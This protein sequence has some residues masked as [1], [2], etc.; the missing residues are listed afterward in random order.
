MLTEYIIFED[1]VHAQV[2][3]VR[4]EDEEQAWK[5]YLEQE[6]NYVEQP[7]G[8]Y[9]GKPSD[10]DSLK[11]VFGA[12][13][14]TLHKDGSYSD[15]DGLTFRSSG[16]VKSFYGIEELSADKVIV[17][18]KSYPNLTEALRQVVGHHHIEIDPCEIDSSAAIQTLFVSR[19]KWDYVELFAPDITTEDIMSDIVSG[20]LWQARRYEGVGRASEAIVELK[21][22]LRL[23]LS[24]KEKLNAL[25]E[26][27]RL[28]VLSGQFV[29]AAKQYQ[30]VLHLAT[31]HDNRGHIRSLLAKVYEEM[32]QLSKALWHYKR[33]LRDNLRDDDLHD[34]D[35]EAIKKRIAAL[36][37]ANFT[38]TTA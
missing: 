5:L 1:S 11:S 21:K 6:E 13:G 10:Y 24:R 16:E 4:A 22:M 38:T 35:I 2:F 30:Q 27:G 7:D 12:Y 8:T 36:E 9:R 31:E 37:Q 18:G 20:Y 17:Y 34:E 33:T 29:R 14:I 25:F 3:L 19:D 26:L 23:T 15:V 32:G 28:Y